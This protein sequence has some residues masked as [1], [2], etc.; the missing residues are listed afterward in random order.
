MRVLLIEPMALLRGA[1]ARV[2]GSEPDLSVVAEVGRY[3]EVTSTGTPHPHV[4]VVGLDPPSAEGL[5]A[6]AW[7]GEHLPGCALLVVTSVE[8]AE[9]TWQAVRGAALDE[10]VSG[11][12]GTD[13][14]PAQLVRYI[15]RAAAGARVLDPQLR[16]ARGVRRSPLT[17]REREIIRLAATGMSDRE[18]AS[19]LGLSSGTVRNYLS[20]VISKT[21]ARNRV[22]AVHLARRVGWI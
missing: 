13:N 15:R 16:A 1:L 8:G 21:G 9:R 14:T 11:I 12:I 7:L 3:A 6:L 2:L 5:A 10:R 22:E 18:I 17:R 19:K 4:A 20:G